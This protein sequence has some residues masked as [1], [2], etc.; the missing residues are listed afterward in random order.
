MRIN[1]VKVSV[2]TRR[3]VWMSL[4]CVILLTQ[5]AQG[6]S[7]DT[8]KY[9]VKCKIDADC[10]PPNIVCGNSNSKCE[11]KSLFPMTDTEIGAIFVLL[12]LTSVAVVV[13]LSGGLIL[14]PLT[15]IML[16]FNA[17][18]AVVLANCIVLLLTFAKYIMGLFKRN[19][20]VEFKTIVDYNMAIAVI[21]WITL[22]STI[23]GIITVFLPDVLVLLLLAALLSYSIISTII[24]T[25]RLHLEKKKEKNTP[26]TP[27]QIQ[28]LPPAQTPAITNDIPKAEIPVL[29]I[30]IDHEENNLVVIT[31]P[32]NNAIKANEGD[33]NVIDSEHHHPIIQETGPL[34]TIENESIPERTSDR[35]AKIEEIKKMEGNNFHWKKICV[36]LFVLI[37]SIMAALFRGGSG[38]NSVVGIKKC[39]AGDFGVLAAYIALL[40]FLPIYSYTVIFREQDLKKEIGYDLDRKE[41][42]LSRKDFWFTVG[43]SGFT[44]M[45]TTITG[46]GGGVLLNPWFSVLHISPVTASWTINFMV[47]LSKIAAVIVA[48]VGGQVLYSYVFFYGCLVALL[49]LVIENSVLIVVKK[50]KSQIMLPLGMI[51]ILL[52]SFILNVYLTVHIWSEKEKAGKPTWV[53]ADYC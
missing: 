2:P 3:V 31:K 10:S 46:L 6:Q 49:M 35:K 47:L 7:T 33:K 26:I 36:V 9:G 22:F 50:T 13:G 27:T 40:F 1:K 19:P 16:G 12:V 44:G 8:S 37:L 11:H 42:I 29:P 53:F 45:I 5:T 43:Y 17:K 4:L 20:E 14:V 52:T 28:N 15:I 34:M 41:I 24:L 32:S 48:V 25:R 30:L 51:A 38:A 21:P 23:G 18:Q 39:S